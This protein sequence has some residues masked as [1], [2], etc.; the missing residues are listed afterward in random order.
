MKGKLKFLDKKLEVASI[1]ASKLL[2]IV[3]QIFECFQSTISIFPLMLASIFEEPIWF[4]PT[5]FFEYL[6][7]L[8]YECW[9]F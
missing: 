5:V 6:L 9:N 8:A 2:I 3:A 1:P 7:K 4:I